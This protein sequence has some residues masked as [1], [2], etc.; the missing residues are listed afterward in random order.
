MLSYFLPY[1]FVMKM[2]YNK[3]CLIS[4]VI[5]YDFF[6]NINKKMAKKQKIKDITSEQ[7]DKYETGK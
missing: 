3:Y 4:L 1:V 6:Y 7:L 5:S 2:M